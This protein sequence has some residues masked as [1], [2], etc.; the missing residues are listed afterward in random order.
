MSNKLGC[1]LFIFFGV[2][3]VL[4]WIIAAIFHDINTQVP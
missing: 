1:F 3:I 2:L 4:L